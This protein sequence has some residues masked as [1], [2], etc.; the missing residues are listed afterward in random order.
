M[1]SLN[2]K[3]VCLLYQPVWHVTSNHLRFSALF[4]AHQSLLEG[5]KKKFGVCL[6]IQLL[7]LEYQN[8]SYITSIK[9]KLWCGSLALWNSWIKYMAVKAIWTMETLYS[10]AQLHNRARLLSRGV[11]SSYLW[12][13]ISDGQQQHVETHS[14]WE[15]PP[16]PSSHHPRLMLKIYP[17]DI[18]QNRNERGAWFSSIPDWPHIPFAILTTKWLLARGHGFMR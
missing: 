11:C 12:R 8:I 1:A 6:K 7:W 14:K 2:M 5:S 16:P 18:P 17:E 13:L 4:S 15:D 3:P 10:A 9:H